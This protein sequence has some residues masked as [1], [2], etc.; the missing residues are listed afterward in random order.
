MPAI[1]DVPKPPPPT[2]GRG[3]FASLGVPI[4]PPQPIDEPVPEPAPEPIRATPQ[5]VEEWIEEEFKRFKPNNSHPPQLNDEILWRGLKRGRSGAVS[6]QVEY[7][8][9]VV[10]DMET[11]SDG[12]VFYMVT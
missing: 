10:R 4:P 2:K 12:N 6:T 7:F 5:M 9:D 1:A 3:K 8:N 11:D